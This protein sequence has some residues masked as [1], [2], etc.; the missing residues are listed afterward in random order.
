[1][2]QALFVLII[3]ML[4]AV[5]VGQQ[6]DLDPCAT[7]E[8]PCDPNRPWMRG[9]VEKSCARA[10]LVEALKRQHPGRI[11][12]AC[13][14]RHT[15]D[16]TKEDTQHRGWSALCEARCSPSNCSCPHPCQET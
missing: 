3:A 6:G 4:S 1:M 11:I 10:G 7:G 13:E 12:L 5:A 2:R 16:K 15:C 9:R 8:S 14:C